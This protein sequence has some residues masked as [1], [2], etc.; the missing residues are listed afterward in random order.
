MPAD[1]GALARPSA[2]AYRPRVS[3]APQVSDA[4][5]VLEAV[6][7]LAPVIRAT[8]DGIERDRRVPAELVRALAAADVFRLCV[9]RALG[10]A[11]AHPETMV[12]VLE[13]IGHAD[14]S[15][16]WS[17]MIGATSGVASAYLA[18]EAAREIYGTPSAITGGAFAALGT[19]AVVEGGYRVSGRW[20][21]ASGCEHCTWLMG[22]SIVVDGGTTR[23]LPSGAPDARLMLFPAAAARIVDTWTVAGLRGTGSHDIAVDDVFVPAAHSLS[24]ITDRPFHARPLYAFPVFGLLALGIAA[25]ALGIGRAAIDELVRLA[26][27]KTPTGSRRRLAERAAVQAQVAEAEAII[28]AARALVIDTIR[29]AWERARGEGAIDLATRAR[30]RL[31]ATHATTSS[32][33]VVDLMYGAGGGTVVYAASPLQ[34]QFRDIH[35]ATQHLMVSPATLELA[36]R[37]LLGLD[38]DTSML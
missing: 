12:A 1:P 16:G 35:V 9:P 6:R 10:G 25:V 7:A 27:A 37:V 33:R 24:L 2:F 22:G 3:E 15:A 8:A 32:A 31:A 5:R 19:A 30:L 29:A 21:F 13:T 4:T 28:G 20:P 14:G 36:G 11:E 18:P 17:A 34:R 23:L 26:G 38:A